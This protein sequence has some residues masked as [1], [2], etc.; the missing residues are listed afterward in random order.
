MGTS[1]MLRFWRKECVRAL[2]VGS[3]D[4]RVGQANPQLPSLVVRV[5]INMVRFYLT[6]KSQRG[7]VSNLCGDQRHQRV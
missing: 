2:R 4:I 7:K 6:D 3:Q 5:N 1:V